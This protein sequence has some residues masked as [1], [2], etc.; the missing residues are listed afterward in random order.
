MELHELAFRGRA[1]RAARKESM[2]A[3]AFPDFP[4]VGEALQRLRSASHISNH[5][6][7]PLRNMFATRV[8]QH[9]REAF[10]S[11]PMRARQAPRPPLPAP[12]GVDGG[13]LVQLS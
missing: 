5:A 12:V 6:Y 7:T 9:C 8:Y 10:G 3:H 1:L 13:P 2:L 11:T 4:P